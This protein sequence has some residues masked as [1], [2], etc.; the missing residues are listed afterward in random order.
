MEIKDIP[1]SLI[2]AVEDIKNAILQSQNKAARNVNTNQL[3]LYFSIGR[4]ISN[5]SRMEQ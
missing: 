2:R 3:T 1:N 5:H 4:Y